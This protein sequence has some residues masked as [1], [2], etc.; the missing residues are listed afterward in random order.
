M[1]VYMQISG[2]VGTAL[3]SYAQYL[4]IL[5][6]SGRLYILVFSSLGFDIQ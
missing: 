2:S 6:Q 5:I 1:P 4:L 3:D